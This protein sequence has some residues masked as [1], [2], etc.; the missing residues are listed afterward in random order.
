MSVCWNTGGVR[1]AAGAHHAALDFLSGALFTRGMAALAPRPCR[2]WSTPHR[3]P[4]GPNPSW[5]NT[6]RD[7]VDYFG[8][9]SVTTNLKPTP[10]G[11]DCGPSA[12]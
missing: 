9:S 10:C 8:N 11:P 3:A 2:R 6:D 12:P 5:Q 4:T 1:G 7:A